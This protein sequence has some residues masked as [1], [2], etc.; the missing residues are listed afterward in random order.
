M[1]KVSF[2]TADPMY[3]GLLKVFAQENRAHQTEAERCLWECLRSGNE[4][5]RFKRQH[6]IGRYIA[7]FI[8]IEAKLIIEVDGGYHCQK[9]Q[10][11]KDFYRTEELEKL[12]FKIIRFNNDEIIG[13]I[14]EV[15]ETIINNIERKI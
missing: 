12:G 5:Y 3:Y 4:G 6:I 9:E 7:D 15:V 1:E 13:N 14:D 8:C 10:M 2:M 11:E